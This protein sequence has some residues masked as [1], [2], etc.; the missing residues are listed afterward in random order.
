[1]E[2]IVLGLRTGYGISLKAI[3][4]KYGVLVPDTADKTMDEYVRKG[5][6][7]AE[8]D[9][10]HLTDSGFFISDRI[11]DHILSKL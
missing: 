3:Y 10:I 7:K 5:Y 6:I 11:V 8:D 2:D 1:R 9:R 4:E